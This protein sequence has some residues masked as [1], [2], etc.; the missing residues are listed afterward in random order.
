MQGGPYKHLLCHVDMILFA[1]LL[2]S[3]LATKYRNTAFFLFLQFYD[4]VYWKED[5]LR[6]E[7]TKQFCLLP[8]NKIFHFNTLF[9][10]LY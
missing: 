5:L 6:W 3:P 4:I 9:S 1:M 2:I 8:P 10:S 7:E